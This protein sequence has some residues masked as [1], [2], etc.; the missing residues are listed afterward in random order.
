[1]IRYRQLEAPAQ[2]ETN[3]PDTGGR[4]AALSLANAF[5]QFEGISSDLG[6]SIAQSAGAKAGAEAG[7]S[8][9]PEFKRGLASLGNYA[10]AYN[11]SAYREYAVVAEAQ[12]EDAAA[13]TELTANGDPVSFV[14]RMSAQRD[15][16]IA[17]AQPEVRA[18]MNN[19]YTQHISAG[20]NRLSKQQFIARKEQD[21]KIGAEGVS[22]FVD[23][24]SRGL[25]T[26]DV[27]EHELA[28]VEQEK[29]SLFIDSLHADGT[30][31][32]VQRDSLHRQAQRGVVK[33]TVVE[34]F[35]NE[36]SNPRGNPIGFINKLKAQNAID[37]V[38]P[39][40]EEDKLM[41]EVYDVLREHN[42]LA[43][44]EAE[45]QKNG[46]KAK[47]EAGFEQS[48]VDLI[49]GQLTPRKIRERV[50]SQDL[51]AEKA[52][53][54][55]NELSESP[56]KTDDATVLAKTELFL[57]DMSEDEIMKTAGLSMASRYELVGKR[58]NQ[59]RD[60]QGSPEV[61]QAKER[62]NKVMGVP[63]GLA[64]ILNPEMAAKH[65]RAHKTLYDTLDALPPSERTVKAVS[66]AEEVIRTQLRSDK[67]K[68]AE[69]L[70]EALAGWKSRQKSPDEMNP[71]EK[72]A[73]TRQVEKKEAEIREAELEAAK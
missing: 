31:T 6:S 68:Q 43:N 25:A 12:V 23:R 36:L 66:T 18:L 48:V 35:R 9:S 8:G 72:A 58:R 67:A 69:F 50:L 40:E 30:V 4:A 62:I 42:S 55:R 61:A 45:Q 65:A 56:K 33:Q 28:T 34:K 38:L 15:K 37:E 22:R 46:A 32:E 51:S 60:W 1:M 73:F 20:A 39:P 27:K 49:N 71:S 13:Q 21:F 26:N 63:S 11:N 7:A 57:L 44:L 2:I 3:I 17:A 19:L 53:Q 24:I 47:E 70:K 59:A 29:L 14:E 52:L 10:K 16:T 54:L 5:K 64:T 41:A